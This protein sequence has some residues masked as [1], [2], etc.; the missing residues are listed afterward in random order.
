MT[1]EETEAHLEHCKTVQ[2]YKDTMKTWWGYPK[3]YLYLID[4]QSFKE[5]E[6]ISDFHV[7]EDTLLDK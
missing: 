7:F 3:N 1:P 2:W 5:I 6:G 4:E